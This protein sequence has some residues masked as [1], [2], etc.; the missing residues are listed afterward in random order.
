MSCL[1]RALGEESRE[2][3]REP[4]KTRGNDAWKYVTMAENPE[5]VNGD[6][7]VVTGHGSRINEVVWT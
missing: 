3:S 7:L 1:S 2:R 6:N 5:S 4:N